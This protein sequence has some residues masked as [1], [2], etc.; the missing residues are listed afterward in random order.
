MVAIH[1][2]ED[3]VTVTIPRKPTVV[4]I[5]LETSSSIPRQSG[6]TAVVIPVDHLSVARDDNISR[7]SAFLGIHDD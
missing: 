7:L 6:T 3:L 5:L 4:S 1:I 2:P